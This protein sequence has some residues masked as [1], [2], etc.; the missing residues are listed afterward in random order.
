[1]DFVKADIKSPIFEGLPFQELTDIMAIKTPWERVL[2]YIH[3][4]RSDQNSGE[5][6]SLSNAMW[7]MSKMFKERYL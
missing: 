1:M 4:K 3:G 2:C 7:V 6:A 5:K